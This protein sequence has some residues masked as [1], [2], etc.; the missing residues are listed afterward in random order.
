[1]PSGVEQTVLTVYLA[2]WG[3]APLS[4][5]CGAE[6]PR[7]ARTRVQR[8]HL[9]PHLVGPGLLRHDDGPGVAG[10]EVYFAR[11]LDWLVTTP[12]LLLALYWTA[13]FRAKTIHSARKRFSVFVILRFNGIPDLVRACKPEPRRAFRHLGRPER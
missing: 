2:L 3:L 1:M 10:S 4:S 7:G 8:G 13:T 9:H 12:P 5:P 11:Y 6:T